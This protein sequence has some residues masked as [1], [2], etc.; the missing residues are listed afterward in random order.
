MIKPLLI[1]S[2]EP[3]GIGPDLC[4][5]L[6]NLNLPIVV[7]GCK[8]LLED[9]AK[10][11]G[12]ALQLQDYKTENHQFLAHTLSIIDLPT[13]E[14]VI[15][16]QL[17]IKNASY[18]LKMLE[19]ATKACLDKTFSGLVTA[20]VHK[21]IINQ[22]GIVFSGHTEFLAQQC[23]AEQVIMMLAC[24]QLKV[25]LA[26]THLPLKEVSQALNQDLLIRIIK[27]LQ[28]SLQEDFAIANPR[29][30]VAGLNPHAGENGYLGRE[31]IDI[32]EPALNQ[33]RQENYQLLGPLPADTMFTPH[34]LEK[35]DVFLAMYH[36]QGLPVLKYAGF[37]E[38]VN[39]S[40]GLPIIRTSVDH[41]TALDL[42]GTG[43]ANLGSLIAAVNLAWSMAQTRHQHD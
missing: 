22:A 36:D 13:P 35:S 6:A 11:L 37:G 12:L 42:A 4:L 43:K 1:T 34:Y 19:Q 27:Q 28:L 21:G 15:A 10:K 31:E 7:L 33:L 2:G 30:T 24:P 18:V 26:T 41:G 40:L 9:R 29:I 38:A 14:Q 8:Q 5:A 39:V 20:P 23:Q 17:N 25:A 32:I 16:G 3:A